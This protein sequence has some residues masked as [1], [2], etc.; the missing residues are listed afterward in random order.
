MLC[1][2]KGIRCGLINGTATA[3]VVASGYN[4]HEWQSFIFIGHVVYCPMY[5][6]S[7]S[8]KFKLVHVYAFMRYLSKFCNIG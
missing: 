2:I 5:L 6:Y 3:L 8:L 7:L 1:I 4:M